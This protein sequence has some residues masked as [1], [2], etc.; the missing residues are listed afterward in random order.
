MKHKQ[1]KLGKKYKKR[2]SEKVEAKRG[3]FPDDTLLIR[4]EGNP[5]GGIQ[6]FPPA[7]ITHS[8]EE[9]FNL[10]YNMAKTIKKPSC[11]CL[12]GELG[13]GK[14]VFAKGF[15]EGL[16]LPKDKIKSPTYTLIRKYK[17]KDSKVIFY[18]CDF[19]RIQA[20]DDLI[21]SDLED[22]IREKY[23]IT[24]IE[25]PER[26]EKLL[27]AQKVILRFESKGNDER[28]ITINTAL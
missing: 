25:W 17:V 16:G 1:H 4:K 22:M 23:A 20:I 8:E 3:I 5:A 11:I 21:S 19:Y 13:S 9:T 15:A 10:G 18:H 24:I 6:A 28:E 7:V 27:P 2:S 12:Y 14:T 26:V